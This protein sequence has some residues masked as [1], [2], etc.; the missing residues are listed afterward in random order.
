MHRPEKKTTLAHKGWFFVSRIDIL[1]YMN[2]NTIQTIS[3]S[4]AEYVHKNRKTD[5]F[6]GLALIALAGAGIA[7][8]FANYVFGIFILISAVV[9]IIMYS[10][11]PAEIAFE[12]NTDGIK[13]GKDLHVYKDINGFMVKDMPR[14]ILLIETKNYFLPI[15]TIPL[16]ENMTNSVR[17]TLSEV[18]PEVELKQSPSMQFIEKVGL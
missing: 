17:A 6:W 14:E 8:Y 7:F 15:I 16:K 2:E 10:Q 5:W 9:M 3:W 4:A 11:P 1:V 12:I 18:L 13:I